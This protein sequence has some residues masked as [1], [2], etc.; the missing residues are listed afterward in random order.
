VAIKDVINI[1]KTFPGKDGEFS[2]VDGMVL[3][4]IEKTEDVSAQEGGKVLWQQEG[5]RVC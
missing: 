3:E 4:R 5:I 2:A 1:L